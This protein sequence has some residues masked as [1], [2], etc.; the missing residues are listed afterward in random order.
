MYD[1]PNVIKPLIASAA[2]SRRQSA[3]DSVAAPPPPLVRGVLGCVHGAQ[4][5]HRSGGSH[6]L[7]NMWLNCV[8]SLKSN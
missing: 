4:K 8:T 6:E 1:M 3:S 2:S 5:C 7:L